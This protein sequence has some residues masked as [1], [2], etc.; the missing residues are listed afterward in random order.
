MTEDTR[1]SRHA[2]ADAAA[3]A[4]AD[5]EARRQALGAV[6]D[7]EQAAAADLLLGLRSAARHDPAA[8]RA[9]LAAVLRDVVADQ[10]ADLRDDVRELEEAVADQVGRRRARA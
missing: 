6:S 8:L 9:L 5:V 2:A 3:R 7:I 1:V 4:A 10:T